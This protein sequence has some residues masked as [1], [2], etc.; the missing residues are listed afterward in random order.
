MLDQFAPNNYGAMNC[1]SFF[2]GGRHPFLEGQNR[3]LF[4]RGGGVRR[5]KTVSAKFSRR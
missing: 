4:Y 5:L 2:A 3:T 1:N